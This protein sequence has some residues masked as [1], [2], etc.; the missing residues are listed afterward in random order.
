VFTLVVCGGSFAAAELYHDKYRPAFEESGY[1]RLQQQAFDWCDRVLPDYPRFETQAEHASRSVLGPIVMLNTAV[2][3]AWKLLP[4]SALL[5]C[6]FMHWPLSGRAFQ[7]LGST[8]SHRSLLHLA[9]NMVGLWSF[10]H[11]I[12][13]AV[14]PEN[15]LA[16]YLSAG[17]LSA[18]ANVLVKVACKSKVPTPSLGASGAVMALV[19]MAAASFPYSQFVF[20]GVAPPVGAE[21]AL[22]GLV[23]FETAGVMAVA[24]G[25]KSP[26]A[27]AAHL[28][29]LATGWAFCGGGRPGVTALG[30]YQRWVRQCVGPRQ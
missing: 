16:G 7:L 19:A 14:G 25:F 3:A 2:Y 9:C 17:V 5:R 1:G 29:G 4:N 24:C 23:A 15:F 20:F 8:F 6:N 27:H 12:A 28:G 18:F 30:D 10:G 22:Q 11:A 26:V 13:P 21:K